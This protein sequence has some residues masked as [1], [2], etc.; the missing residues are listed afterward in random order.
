MAVKKIEGV[1]PWYGATGIEREETHKSRT[2]NCAGRSANFQRGEYG[3]ITVQG[4]N[5]HPPPPPP[6]STSWIKRNTL[7]PVKERH[8]TGQGDRYQSVMAARTWDQPDGRSWGTS[9]RTV[10][11][12]CYMPSDS[13][14]QACVPFMLT[15][16]GRGG[17][18]DVFPYLSCLAPGVPSR[19]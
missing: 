11:L 1:V 2:L 19:R 15:V 12:T 4:L 3:A 9:S 8:A 13:Y 18:W 17:T 6:I 5:M 16:F 7:C 14:V 10:L